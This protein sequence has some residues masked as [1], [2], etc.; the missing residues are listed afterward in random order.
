MADGTPVLE[1]SDL[2]VRYGQ[3]EA[4]RGVDLTLPS[5]VLAL[6]G[7][8][9]MGKSTLCQTI[10]G[11][12]P[13]ASGDVRI[14]GASV[15]GLEPHQVQSRGVA[16]VPQGRRVWPGLSVDEHLRVVARRG[17]RWTPERVYAAFPRLAE[18]R[19]NSG[20]DLSGGEQ[21]MLAIGRALLQEPR[22]LVMDEPTEG[23]APVIV[24]RI[25]DLLVR[26]AAEEEMS[27]L[28]V[29]QNLAAALRCAPRVAVMVGGRIAAEMPSA[30]L[31]ADVTL[32]RRLIGVSGGDPA[33]EAPDAPEAGPEVA[34]PPKADVPTAPRALTRW[35]VRSAAP[36]A[37]PPASPPPRRWPAPTRS[38]A[39]PSPSGPL[40]LP[41]G[42][43]V[44]VAGTFDTKS[45]E[46][47]FLADRLRAAGLRALTVD[48][49]TSRAHG[50]AR[51]D[52]GPRDVA[53]A[54]PHGADA[55]FTGDR[56]T[57]VTAMAE[58]FALWL[59]RR[60]DLAG[61]ISA[62]GS[63]ATALVAPALRAL[64]VGVPK[65]IVSTVASGDVAPYVGVSDITMMHSVTDVSGLNAISSGV[66]SN[67][68]HAMAGMA[69]L[70]RPAP[71]SR[72]AAGLS[73]FGVT[74]PCVQSLAAHVEA[75]GTDA[76]VFHATGTG[77]RAMEKLAA[78]GALTSL[79]DVTLTEVADHFCG[80]VM[81][82]GEGRL[83]ILAE[84]AIPWVGSTGALDMVNWGAPG[85]VPERYAG[86]LFYKH[87]PQVT[88]MRTTAEEC[89]V[90]GAFI[91]ARLAA[92]RGPVRMLLPDGGVSA[93]DAPGM[94]FHDLEATAALHDAIE[95]AIPPRAGLRIERLPR[96]VNDPAFAAALHAAW[97]EVSRAAPARKVPA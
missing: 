8:N 31:A 70:E 56:G 32:Q 21:Q 96:H 92:A 4:L 51:C 11:L 44:L 80:G 25:V 26:L 93:L 13:I 88:L 40:P 23:L 91:G 78:E 81:S 86:R 41:A 22:L 34:P 68:A 33:T 49:S 16:Y 71:P 6:V 59:P 15:A 54:H 2:H 28:L 87:N 82:A 85:T 39:T 30:D 53:R 61:V 75:D 55:V 35:S 62:G 29:E 45:R 5:G 24:D 64:P 79:L 77:G 46:L 95:A 47:G 3:A 67:A 18:R 9:G 83:S 60:R 37:E 76:I 89:R 57:A 63:G 1:V 38:A 42:R 10:L 94:P 84:R 7:R 12:V 66:L 65:L 90:F 73:M 19:G 48:L 97:R 14:A 72:P 74:T 17:A 58:A 27:I 69:A 52:I 36:E 20:G 43:A 50:G